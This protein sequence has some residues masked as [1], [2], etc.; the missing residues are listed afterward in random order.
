MDSGLNDV[1][2][3]LFNVKGLVAL[4]TGGGTGSVYPLPT[5]EYDTDLTHRKQTRHRPYDG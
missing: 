1:V 3:P 4:V 5:L 2:E